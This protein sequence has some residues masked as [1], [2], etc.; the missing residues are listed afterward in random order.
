MPAGALR[1]QSGDAI[2]SKRSDPI[3]NE[4]WRSSLHRRDCTDRVIISDTRLVAMK[5]H[6]Q[7]PR[8]GHSH[9]L[10]N[11]RI[12]IVLVSTQIAMEKVPLDRH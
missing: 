4:C 12:S 9:A 6:R 5:E 1:D 7:Q 10:L 3:D 8:Q 11:P 2:G